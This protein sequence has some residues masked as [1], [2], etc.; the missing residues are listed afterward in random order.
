MQAY[1][2]LAT[3]LRPLLWTQKGLRDFLVQRLSQDPNNGATSVE[4]L[5][6]VVDTSGPAISHGRA[7]STVLCLLSRLIVRL[8]SSVAKYITA[9]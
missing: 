7:C 1:W 8:R 3:Y 9:M 4:I 5:Y 6:F 2:S